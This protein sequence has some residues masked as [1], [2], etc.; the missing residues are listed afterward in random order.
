MTESRAVASPIETEVIRN[1]LNACA[2]DMNAALVRSA[3]TPVIYEGRDC[4]VAVL[5]ENAATLGQSTGV[6]FFLGTLNACVELTVERFGP[7]WMGPGDV[8]LMNDSYLQGTHLND[9]TVFTPIHFEGELV[10]YS[11]TRAH[12]LDIGNKD[13]GGS[14]DSTEI[15]QEGL[16]LPPTRIVRGGEPV[17]GWQE[18]IELNTRYPESTIGDLNAQIVACRMGERRMGEML[19]RFGL[20]KFRDARGKIFAGSEAS[21]RAAIAAIPD[22]VYRAGGTMDDDGFGSDPIPLQVAV[23]VDGENLSVDL[24]GTGPFGKG[25]MNCGALQ[26]LSALRLAYRMLINPEEPVTG[27]TFP[28]FD[29]EVPEGCFLNA[30]EPVPCQWHFTGTGLLI[31]LFIKALAPAMPRRSAAA[32]YGDSMVI[33]WDGH[34]P[35]TG[36]R[37]FH[38]VEPTPGG[39]G[40]FEGGDGESSLI[41]NVNGRFRSIPVE[42]FEAKYPVQ[43]RSWEL[44]RDSGGAG[45]FRGGVGIRK[46]FRPWVNSRVFLWFERSETPAWGLF[47]GADAVGPQ[48]Q[49]RDPDGELVWEGLKANALAVPEGYELTIETGGGGGYGNPHERDPEA[50]AADVADG[51]VSPESAA[52]RYGRA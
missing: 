18:L 29:V 14:M 40:A 15:Y 42:V 49:L 4:A 48:I 9:A 8:I 11:A 21:D 36:G 43:I 20:A 51:F 50:V 16:R 33:A 45:R 28:T 19:S 24:E 7:D 12:W 38:S 52:S 1:F 34:D 37:S 25:P 6:P 26:T 41:N 44:R 47:G 22:G 32:H 23:E 35:R 17:E 46:V 5:D 13:P 10:G 39:W 3:Y 27:G 2:E 30:R 31:D